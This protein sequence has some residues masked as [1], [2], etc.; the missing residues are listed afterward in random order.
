MFPAPLG[1]SHSTSAIQAHV[2]VIDGARPGVDALTLSSSCAHSI[3]L[4]TCWGPSWEHGRVLR[5]TYWRRF[6]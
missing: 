3:Q 4:P 5:A 1:C 6:A 2:V